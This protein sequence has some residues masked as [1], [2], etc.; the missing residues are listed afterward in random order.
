LSATRLPCECTASDQHSTRKADGRIQPAKYNTIL[1]KAKLYACCALDDVDE[2]QARKEEAQE[3]VEVTETRL[4]WMK[5]QL[6]T[7]FAKCIVSA[8]NLSTPDHLVDRNSL[9]EAASETVIK[10][11]LARSCKS[12]TR[13]NSQVSKS[14]KRPIDDITLSRVHSSKINKAAGQKSFQ[15]R[16]QSLASA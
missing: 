2:C 3:Q 12:T 1:Q 13:G 7:I 11:Q 9:S 5:Q 6:P 4:I 14:N 8:A 15:S 10:S 16:R